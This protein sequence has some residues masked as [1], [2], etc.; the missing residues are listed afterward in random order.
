MGLE[1]EVRTF[2]NLGFS[3]VVLHDGDR[4]RIVLKA[5]LIRRPEDDSPHSV[6]LVVNRYLR[7]SK[8]QPWPSEPTEHIPIDGAGFDAAFAHMAAWRDVLPHGRST[9]Y[10]T[11]LVDRDNPNPSAI[12]E[13]LAGFRRNPQAF[14][15]VMRLLSADD[16]FALQAASNLARIRQSRDALIR[17]MSEDPPERNLQKW[18]E[19]HPWIFGSE[20]VERLPLRQFGIDAQGDFLL[21]TADGFVDVFEL[22]RPS[23]TVVRW[24]ESHKAWMPAKP[25][26]D[27]LGQVLKYLEVL[28]D[29]KFQLRDRFALPVVYPRVRVVI[30]SSS[31]WNEDQRRALRRLNAH[32]NGIE[33]LTFDHVIA[34]ADVMIAHLALSLG[35]DESDTSEESGGEGR[36]EV[37]LDDLP[38]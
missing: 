36:V 16:A 18:F 26:A 31:D 20:Y 13:L 2:R 9:R 8:N 1:G 22:K 33:I 12:V 6:Q 38:I 4:V 27:A 7:M 35:P 21:R 29:N 14:L 23:A 30:G 19:G 11:L 37:D 25:L 3:E 28:D 10:V 24:E 5:T 15:P 17:L 34:R 32:L